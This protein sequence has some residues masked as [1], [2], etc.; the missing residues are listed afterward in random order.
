LLI[1]IAWQ[2]I[3]LLIGFSMAVAFP[4]LHYQIHVDREQSV[5]VSLNTRA[6]IFLVDEKNYQRLRA[7]E[8]FRYFGRSQRR[9]K[10]VIRPDRS[11]MW[12]IVITE[13]DLPSLSAEVSLLA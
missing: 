3:I 9:D 2:S 7:R 1:N 4:Y 12:H 8:R 13:A 10:V 6:R 11:G 5:Q